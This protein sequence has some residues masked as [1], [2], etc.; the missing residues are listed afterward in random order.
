VSLAA[1]ETA[2]DIE[3]AITFT[4]T[5]TP[6]NGALPATSFEWDVNNDLIVDYTTAANSQAHTY[7]MEGTYTARVMATNG[8]QNGSSTLVITVTAPPLLVSLTT[9]TSTPAIDQLVTFTATVTSTGS[10]PALLRF[11]WDEDNDG[12]YDAVAE[13]SSPSG[14]VMRWGS[15][16]VK[17]V[18]VR[19]TD[20]VS[21]RSATTTRQVTVV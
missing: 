9:D 8:T 6:V 16:G 14:R 10:I 2:T 17:T 5:A 21:G 13:G 20:P 11:E 4:A 19:V 15:V 1:S 12:N 7:P 3:T 18:R